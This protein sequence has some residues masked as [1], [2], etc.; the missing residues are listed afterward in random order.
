RLPC[1]PGPRRL[2][3]P[4]RTSLAGCPPGS[5]K[6]AGSFGRP[7][8][9]PFGSPH[10]RDGGLPCHPPPSGAAG[11]AARTG[12]PSGPPW[13]G[14]CLRRPV[15]PSR[16]SRRT[17]ADDG[18]NESRCP[19]LLSTLCFLRFFAP[20]SGPPASL[21]TFEGDRHVWASPRLVH[22][23]DDVPV[24]ELLAF[25]PWNLLIRPAASCDIAVPFRLPK[26]SIQHRPFGSLTTLA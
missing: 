16:R 2:G 20:C 4:G 6:A 17:R 19:R 7:P 9:R 25:E 10:P 26:S 14:D 15:G 12:T 5:S 22:Q 8:S 23:G 18:A 1:W 3:A 21:A 11:S 13:R 24:G